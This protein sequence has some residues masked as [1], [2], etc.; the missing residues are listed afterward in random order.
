MKKTR[1]EKGITLIALII[2]IVV[3]LILAVVTIGAVQ[4]ST[5]ITHAENAK[6]M[7][8]MKQ[9]EEK[10]KLEIAEMELAEYGKE[11]T[12]IDII[13]KYEGEEATVEPI[14]IASNAKSVPENMPAGNYYIL[15][16]EKYAS[17]NN[18][19]IRK[20]AKLK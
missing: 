17:D 10:I 9:T 7:Y 11:I 20:Y 3:L 13:K 12:V 16:P 5:I 14:S 18:A 15:T 2:T 1:L 8:I 6:E 4:E 19:N